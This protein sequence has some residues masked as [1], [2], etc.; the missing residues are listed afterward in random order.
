MSNLSDNMITKRRTG[1][2]ISMEKVEGICTAYTARPMIFWS[3]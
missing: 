2:Y 1:Q 3:L